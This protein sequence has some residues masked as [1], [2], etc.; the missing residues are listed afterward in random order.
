MMLTGALSVMARFA[1]VLGTDTAYHVT[2]R[3]NARQVVFESG[4][5]RLVYLVD[6]AG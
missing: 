2:Q 6:V 1:R 3:G 4:A 5:D